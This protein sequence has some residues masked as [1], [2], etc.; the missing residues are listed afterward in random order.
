MKTASPDLPTQTFESAAMLRAWLSKHHATSQG[1]WVKVFKKGSGVASVTFGELLDEGLCFGWS[2]S[3][4]RR[5]QGDFYLQRFTPRKTVGT[6][7]KRNQARV[8]QLMDE[9][10]MTKA[11]L[12]ALGIESP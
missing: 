2:E 7:S 1:L 6:Q 5:G 11:G 3:T 10:R 12:A 9:S 4:R 8:Q